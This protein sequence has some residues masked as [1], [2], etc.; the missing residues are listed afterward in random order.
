[1]ARKPDGVSQPEDP[2]E[3]RDRSPPGERLGPLAI[4]RMFKEDGRALIVY[5]ATGSSDE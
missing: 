3:E 2:R 5:R 1:M 4:E